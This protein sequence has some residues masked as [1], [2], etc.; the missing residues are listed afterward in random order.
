MNYQI[1]SKKFKIA[2]PDESLIL[3][4]QSRTEVVLGKSQVKES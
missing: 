4:D 1:Y 3:P 2:K